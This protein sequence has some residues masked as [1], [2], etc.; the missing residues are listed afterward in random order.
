MTIPVEPDWWRARDRDGDLW[1][2]EPDEDGNV[3]RVSGGTAE[4]TWAD[5]VKWWGPITCADEEAV[6]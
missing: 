5:L 3:W 6:A 1:Y 4:W 2:R